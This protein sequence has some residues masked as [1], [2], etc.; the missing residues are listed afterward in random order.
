MQMLKSFIHIKKYGE[1]VDYFLILKRKSNEKFFVTLSV[2][3]SVLSLMDDILDLI[4]V[5]AVFK[6]NIN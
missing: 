4:S 6:Q 2:R 3:V 1:F 5:V